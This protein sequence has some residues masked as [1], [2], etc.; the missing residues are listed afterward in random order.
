MARYSVEQAF[1]KVRASD[2]QTLPTREPCFF[3]T[4]SVKDAEGWRNHPTRRDGTIFELTPSESSIS[5]AVDY[6]WYDYAVQIM[7]G[8]WQR[9][10]ALRKASA[11]MEVK[12]AA[13]HY[14][15]GDTVE[16]EG[17]RSR[18]EVLI[19]GPVLVKSIVREA[20]LSGPI[21]LG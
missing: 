17:G 18:F 12:E 1:E 9:S 7:D 15:G 21:N 8:R 11:E 4:L 14:W 6:G 13:N 20:A 3:A 2:Y 19:A 10:Y 16:D 5:V